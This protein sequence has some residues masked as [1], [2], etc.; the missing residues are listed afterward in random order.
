MKLTPLTIYATGLRVLSNPGG[1]P[2]N[3]R[4]STKLKN[5]LKRKCSELKRLG[6][7]ADQ[8]D[9]P[10]PFKRCTGTNRPKK[11]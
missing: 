6:S 4:K 3:K 1:E 9:S 5:N 11:G 10:I 8:V 7:C 2:I